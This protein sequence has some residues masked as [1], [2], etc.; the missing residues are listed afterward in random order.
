M[1]TSSAP[2]IAVFDK[3]TQLASVD[4]VSIKFAI[5]LDLSSELSCLVVVIIWRSSNNPSFGPW[6]NL[7]ILSAAA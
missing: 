5:A 3:N 4:V 6:A 1:R 2:R 7:T